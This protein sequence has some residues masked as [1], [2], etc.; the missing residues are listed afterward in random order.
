MLRSVISETSI[1]ETQLIQRFCSIL[2]VIVAS[3]CPAVNLSFPTCQ[4]VL[5]TLWSA[6]MYQMCA[7]VFLSACYVFV[8]VKAL[9]SG[10]SGR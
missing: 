6:G 4:C 2:I 7:Y 5:S 1:K 9:L 8:I 10:K 3:N